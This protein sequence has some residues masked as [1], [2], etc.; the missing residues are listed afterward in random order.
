MRLCPICGASN[1]VY[2]GSF[3]YP[4][5]RRHGSYVHRFDVRVYK[6]LNCKA[7]FE[8]EQFVQAV[9][10]DTVPASVDTGV[11]HDVE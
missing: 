5:Y 1:I 6:C 7:D 4:R 10:L 8:E 11:D 9:R 2:R 3:A